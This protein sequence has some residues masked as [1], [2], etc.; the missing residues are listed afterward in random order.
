[1][2]YKEESRI[3]IRVSAIRSKIKKMMKM[4]KNVCVWM[5]VVGMLVAASQAA[6][7]SVMKFGAKADGKTDDSE[8]SN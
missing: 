7:Y 2:N 8:V 1:M 4:N 3:K 5:A 6:E